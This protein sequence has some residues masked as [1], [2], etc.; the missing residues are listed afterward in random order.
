MPTSCS[1][2]QVKPGTAG[3]GSM[4]PHAS[5]CLGCAAI[6]T[7]EI[8]GTLERKGNV[9]DLITNGPAWASTQDIRQSAGTESNP[10]K[11]MWLHQARALQ[12]LADGKNVGVATATASGKSRVFQLWTL[13]ELMTDPEA[14]ALVFYPTKALANDQAYSWNRRCA[15]VGLPGGTVD[16]INGDVPMKLRDGILNTSRVVI[17][18]PDVC[19]AWL[20]RNAETPAVGE[21]LKGLRVVIIDEAHTY[22]SIFG[23]NSAYLFRRLI[24]ASVT[25]GNPNPPQYIAATATILEPATHLH[26]LTGQE[27][28]VIGQEENGAP[29]FSRTLHHLAYHEQGDW[30]SPS[31]QMAE[32][33][34]NIIDNDPQS[35]VI[36]FHDSRQGIE[37]IVQDIGRPDI[38]MP[39]RSGYLSED[40]FEIESRLRDG[41]IRAVITTSALELGIDMPDLNYGI[42]LDL[43]PTR[44]SFH[45]RLGRVGRSAP[46]TFIILAPH[47]RFSDFGETMKDYYDNS[48]EPSLLYLDNEYI[49]YQQA[50]CLKNELENSRKDTRALPKHCVWPVGFDLALRNAH[51]K[52][53]VHLSNINLS[54]QG[55]APQLA[56]SLRSTGE[57]ELKIFPNVARGERNYNSRGIGTISLS[58]ALKEAYPGAV[59]RHMGQSYNV[60]EW[61]RNP[62]NRQGIIKVTNRRQNQDRTKPMTRHMATLEPDDQH[63]NNTRQVA[64]GHIHEIMVKI[65]RSVEGFKIGGGNDQY[66]QELRKT[67]PRK[68]RKQMEFPT[69]GVHIRITEPWFSGDT[70]WPWQTRF[71]ISEA[72]RLHLAYHR[73]IPLAELSSMVENI[74]IKTP[75]GYYLSDDSILVYD[76]IHGGLGLVQHLYDELPMYARKLVLP[77]DQDD[78]RAAHSAARVNNDS[79]KQF[80][81]W[82]ERDPGS[83]V[84]PPPEPGEKDWWRIIINGSEVRVYSEDQREMVLGTV[85]NRYWDEGVKYQVRIG[86]EI[87][88]FT[89]ENIQ[90]AGSNFDYELWNPS[91][92]RTAE[93]YINVDGY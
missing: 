10:E 68:T 57:E 15:D 34:V 85:K 86:Q 25:A 88:N 53:P 14:T 77:D 23:S 70:G 93:F 46:G 32:L 30:T 27:F 18:T 87:S 26:R 89:D 33:V 61:V 54:T 80:L 6:E 43:P 20:T 11:S 21:F 37:R 16:Q 71:Q 62:Q 5:I 72:L 81:E 52:P 51:G 31:Q 47:T 9:P 17:M 40:R 28:R 19:H 49:T 76:N 75:R 92:D 39:Y 58:A 66:Y 79:A 91:I 2:C 50:R 55:Q 29:R 83:R 63:I 65:T 60:D 42:N 74:I 45:Q 36:A 13:H 35:Q 12:E 64:G 84:D 69:S 67:D 1:R 48:V 8:P 38:V 41:K 59:Y 56:H 3:R 7:L 90:Q 78:D 73:S 44:K 24:T 4:P 22:E 82:L